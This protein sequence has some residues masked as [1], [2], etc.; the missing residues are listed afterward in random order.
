MS[1]E[2]EQSEDLYNEQLR[3]QLEEKYNINLDIQTELG[4]KTY[5]DLREYFT[6]EIKQDNLLIR[7]DWITMC[8]YRTDIESMKEEFNKQLHELT[9]YESNELCEDPYAELLESAIGHPCQYVA[10]ST[11]NLDNNIIQQET[12]PYTI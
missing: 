3:K 11:S 5:Y 12:P 1:I 2:R 9:K 6:K 8:C 4:E 7:T 10:N